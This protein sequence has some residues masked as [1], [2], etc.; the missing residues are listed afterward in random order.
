MYEAP[1]DSYVVHTANQNNL[2]ISFFNATSGTV[3]VEQLCP[4]KCL[5]A[6]DSGLG[7]EYSLVPT[8]RNPCSGASIHCSTR[9]T[10]KGW[11]REAFFSFLVFSYRVLIVFDLFVA[12]SNQSLPVLGVYLP[13][14]E[15][16]GNLLLTCPLVNVLGKD[17]HSSIAQ[18]TF[19]IV[20]TEQCHLTLH[21]ESH[22]SCK[23]ATGTCRSNDPSQI[24]PNWIAIFF[25]S[26]LTTTTKDQIDDCGL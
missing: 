19:P 12:S 10:M 6:L 26:V 21:R 11:Y 13:I 15:T 20:C 5:S 22:K 24:F 2:F 8:C 25:L 1:H 18:L 9:N 23:P 14:I 17:F 3:F 4:A 16:L 7:R